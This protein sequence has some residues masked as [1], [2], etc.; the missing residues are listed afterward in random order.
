M[1]DFYTHYGELIFRILLASLLGGLIGLERD[2]H[3][4]AAGLRTH[5]LVS[6]GAAVFTILSE[7]ISRQ[8]S[9][10]GLISDPARIAAQVVSGIGFLGAG[11]I[12]KEGVNV[13]GLTTAA[14]LWGAA[15]IGMAAGSGF[16]AIAIVATIIALIS[17]TF[18]KLVEN[19]YSK[20]TYR[21]LSVQTHIEVS[22]AQIIENVKS[23]RLKIVNCDIEKNYETGISVTRLSILLRYR[24]TA[25]KQAQDIIESL[26][27]SSLAIKE[28]KWEHM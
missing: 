6:M 9:T 27:R 16:Y 28:V 4:R 22:A 21:M 10:T 5:L 14:C 26:E 1:P 3:G 2:V 15:A 20:D 11:V 12:I 19:Y 18:L 13:H 25:D 24:G 23:K 8:A 17:L 7:V